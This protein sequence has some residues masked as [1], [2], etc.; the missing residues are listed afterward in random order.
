[1]TGAA[2]LPAADV[3]TAM[4]FTDFVGVRGI[5]RQ[6]QVV[7]IRRGCLGSA[8]QPLE[9]DPER[10]VER[11]VSRRQRDRFLELTDCALVVS[12]AMQRQREVVGGR[13]VIWEE[14]LGAPVAGNA[15]GPVFQQTLRARA[16]ELIRPSIRV[17]LNRLAEVRQRLRHAPQAHEHLSKVAQG[18]RILGISSDRFLIVLQRRLEVSGLVR[19]VRRAGGIHERPLCGCRRR[20]D[21]RGMRGGPSRG[22]RIDDR[23]GRHRRLGLW[24]Q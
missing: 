5:W 17:E 9:A 3:S 8:I 11:P 1:M 4:S 6:L 14:L 15:L 7:G 2:A 20:R 21:V 23:S 16:I 18:L 22:E 13:V 19:F 12:R 10:P 24:R